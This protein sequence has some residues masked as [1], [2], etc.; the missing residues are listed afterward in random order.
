MKATSTH[1][2]KSTTPLRQCLPFSLIQ[3][4][5]GRHCRC[6]IAIMGVVDHLGP[7]LFS[8]AYNHKSETR[9]QFATLLENGYLLL[10]SCLEVMMSLQG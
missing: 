1:N 9:N 10:L 4:Q 8:N 2:G 3:I 6:P 5:R 7:V